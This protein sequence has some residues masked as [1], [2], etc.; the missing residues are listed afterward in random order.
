MVQAGSDAW[1][2][3]IMQQV[4]QVMQLLGNPL[5]AIRSIGA[6]GLLIESSDFWSPTISILKLWWV[7]HKVVN[8]VNLIPGGCT[9][10]TVLLSSVRR[11]TRYHKPRRVN[12][13]VDCLFDLFYYSSGL[14]SSSPFIITQLYMGNWILIVH[15]FEALSRVLL[16][17]TNKKEPHLNL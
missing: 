12:T 8:I 16:F 3:N 15:F 14:S 11:S 7:W 5:C 6:T 2:N 17:L 9:P 10:T 13:A 4:N 1:T